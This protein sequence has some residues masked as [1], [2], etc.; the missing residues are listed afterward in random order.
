MMGSRGSAVGIVTVYGLDGRGL[1]FRI[2]LGTYFSPFHVVQTGSGAHTASY[3]MDTGALSSRVKRP[4]R[5]A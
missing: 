5:E 3:L 4:G 2:P 1:G